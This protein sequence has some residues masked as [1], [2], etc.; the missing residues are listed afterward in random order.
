M[1]LKP[2]AV[3]MVALGFN[4]GGD[5]REQFTITFGV[6][7]GAYDPATDTVAE[8]GRTTQTVQALPLK[9]KDSRKSDEGES[10]STSRKI[11]IQSAEL[12]A[13]AVI[14]DTDT[15]VDEGGKQWNILGVEQDATKATWTLEID[16]P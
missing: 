6:A 13:A 15:L 8:G 2:L 14:Q 1:N 11:M 4:L 7:A 3:K 16:K 9:K 12:P 10:S 5:L